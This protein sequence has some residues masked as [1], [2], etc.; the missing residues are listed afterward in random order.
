MRSLPLF[1]VAADPGMNPV[2]VFQHN[3][4]SHPSKIS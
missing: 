1:L 4:F 2:D 3:D